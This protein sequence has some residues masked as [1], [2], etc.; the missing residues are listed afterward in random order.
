MNRCRY[1]NDALADYRAPSP[2]PWQP[3]R[4]FVVALALAGMAGPILAL[5]LGG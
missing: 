3:S 5:L 4:A 1:I 2:P